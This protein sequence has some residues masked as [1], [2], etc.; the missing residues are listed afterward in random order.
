[1]THGDEKP[2]NLE[3]ALKNG[4]PML[5]ASAL[6]EFRIALPPGQVLP[7][8]FTLEF[9]LVPKRGSNPQDLSFEGTPTINQDVGSAHVL[10][11]ATPLS[12][13]VDEHRCT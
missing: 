5:K 4:V 13:H 7:R 10:W 3:V 12:W 8:D 1:M 6:S 11:H 2:G 9:D